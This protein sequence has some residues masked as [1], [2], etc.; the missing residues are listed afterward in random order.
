M[1]WE[2][3]AAL[4]LAQDPVSRRLY[5]YNEHYFKHADPGENARAIRA[6]GDWIPGVVDPAACG[7]SQADGQKLIVQY[8]ELGL[9]LT[10]AENTV[11][12]GLSTVR[13][14]LANNQLYIFRSLTCFWREYRLYRRDERGRVLKENDHLMDCPRYGVMSG[15]KKMKTKPVKAAP[16]AESRKSGERGWMT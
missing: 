5:A 16:V 11:Q 1:G 6:R 4:W 10:L 3:T 2:C 15:R 12:A 8:R 9:K 13:E 7:G 14:L